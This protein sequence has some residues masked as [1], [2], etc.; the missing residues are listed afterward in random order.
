MTKQMFGRRLRALRP[1]IE[2]AQRTFEGKRQWVYLGLGLRNRGPAPVIEPRRNDGS[3]QGFR[4][5]PWSQ[6][7][8]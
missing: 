7:A 5:R 4:E 8:E 2:E 6:E 3:Q 1:E